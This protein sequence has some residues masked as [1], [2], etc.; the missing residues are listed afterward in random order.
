MYL[1]EIVHNDMSCLSALLYQEFIGFKGAFITTTH[2]HT[3][4][5]SKSKR[6]FFLALAP[7]L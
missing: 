5:A 4:A 7:L 2:E 1:F 3:Y 6:V